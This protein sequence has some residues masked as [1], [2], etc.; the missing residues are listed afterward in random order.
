MGASTTIDPVCGM[1][2]DPTM[3]LSAEVEGQTYYFCAAGCRKAFVSDPGSFLHSGHSGHDEY[4]GHDEH[5]GH[6]H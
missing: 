5:S 6:Q 2:V 1:T 3:A 4:S